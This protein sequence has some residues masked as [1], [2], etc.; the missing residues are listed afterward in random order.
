MNYYRRGPAD[1]TTYAAALAVATGVGLAAFYLTKLWLQRVPIGHSPR[2]TA[3]PDEGEEERPARPDEITKED[4][5]SGV[6]PEGDAGDGGRARLGT[7]RLAG[8]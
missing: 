4:E 2:A 6:G 8:V 3:R 7:T 5:A 1:A